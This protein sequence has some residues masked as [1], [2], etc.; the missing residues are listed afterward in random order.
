VCGNKLMIRQ[1]RLEARLLSGIAQR[2]FAA[3]SKHTIADATAYGRGPFCIS[4]MGSPTQNQA[5]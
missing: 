1:D 3:T 4:S 2:T 5:I